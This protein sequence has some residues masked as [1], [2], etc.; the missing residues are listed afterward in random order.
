MGSGCQGVMVSGCQGFH[1]PSPPHPCLR[2]QGLCAGSTA[3]WAL[4]RFGFNPSEPLESSPWGAG[5]R[6]ATATVPSRPWLRPLPWAG[7]RGFCWAGNLG[8]VLPA[9]SRPGSHSCAGSVCRE[10]PCQ[11]L[12]WPLPSPAWGRPQA[13]AQGPHA[14][15]V[16]LAGATKLVPGVVVSRQHVPAVL[17]S[18]CC[19]AGTQ[20]DGAVMPAH[21]GGASQQS[22]PLWCCGGNG[23]RFPEVCHPGPDVPSPGVPGPD[24]PGS[25]PQAAPGHQPGGVR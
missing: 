24:V 13:A 7:L 2:R 18:R 23:R 19:R 1:P 20:G 6:K 16:G 17:P 12:P 22:E 21:T 25:S 3:G 9:R 10:W 4:L 5:D 14:C 8:Y 11:A 15:H